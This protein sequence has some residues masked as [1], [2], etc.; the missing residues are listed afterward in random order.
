M[1]GGEPPLDFGKCFSSASTI[2]LELPDV[3]A[4]L[5]EHRPHDARRLPA[6]S[7][8]SKCTGSICGFPASAASSCARPQPLG[9]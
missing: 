9:P 3:R 1:P 8:A 7:A 2:C 6:S 5:L 4:D